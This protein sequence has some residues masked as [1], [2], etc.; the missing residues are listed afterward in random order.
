MKFLNKITVLIALAFISINTVNAQTSRKD[1]KAA[2]VA[3]IKT[4]VEA[5]NY[6]FKANYALPSRGSSRSLT[7]DYDFVVSKDT[8]IAY[9]PYFGRAYT[10]PY[11]PTEGGI[12][13]T[14]TH[15][16]YVSK[17]GKKGGWTVT[18]KP[19]GKDKN[20]SDWRDVQILTLSIST[21]GYASLQVISSNRDPISFNGTIEARKK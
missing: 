13:F 16:S 17:A 5:Q 18:I 4:I 21:D 12:K 11:N 1:K 3:E 7:S 10:A 20:I 6:V 19:T 9:L 14:N 2:Q 8:I 15:F